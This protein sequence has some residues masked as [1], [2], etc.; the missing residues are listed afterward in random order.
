MG[1]K[2]G[3][4]IV[5]FAF[6]D[7]SRFNDNQIVQRSRHCT[8]LANSGV[9]FFVLPFIIREC[10]P[11]ILELLYLLQCRSIHLQ[12]ALIRV[13]WKM[14]YLSFG[15]AYFHSGGVACI[16][17]RFNARWRPDSVEESRTKSSANKRR[18]ILQFPTGCICWFNSYKQWKGE[19][20]KRTLAG[21]QRQY[22][23]TLI[24]MH[25]NRSFITSVYDFCKLVWIKSLQ[26]TLKLIK[27]W[28]GYYCFI[29]TIIITK[30]LEI[31]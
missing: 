27:K 17:K 13:S 22:G 4:K 5:S 19:V 15:C 18:L 9:Q 23:T 11:K 29:D 6:F 10:N 7:N 21:V 14:K 1:T 3:L 24:A 8:S 30:F 20:T 31:Y 28:N 16:S 12:H 2:T 25:K 26:C